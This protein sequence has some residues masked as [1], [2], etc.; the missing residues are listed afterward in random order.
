MAS[1]QY[2]VGRTTIT[3]LLDAE[4]LHRQALD[5]LSTA[6]ADYHVRLADYRR[7]TTAQ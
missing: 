5:H 7:K 4:T 6:L 2:T 3:E 1:D